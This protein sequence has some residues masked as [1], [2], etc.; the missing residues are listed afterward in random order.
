MK[1]IERRRETREHAFFF[2]GSA[3]ADGVLADE[4]LI[5]PTRLSVDR[6]TFPK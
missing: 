4:A 5:S 6:N 2:S 3:A 1:R